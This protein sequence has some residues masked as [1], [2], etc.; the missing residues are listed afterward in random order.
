MPNIVL[1]PETGQLSRVVESYQQVEL[2]Q[3]EAESKAAADRVAEV[4]AEAAAVA[5]KL[6]EAQAAAEDSKSQFETGQGLV[7]EP[8]VSDG[9]VPVDGEVANP[10]AQF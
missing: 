8:A 6:A 5:T 2:A 1:H 7:A 10:E 3:L 9:A 4:E